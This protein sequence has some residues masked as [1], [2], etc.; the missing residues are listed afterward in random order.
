M[1]NKILYWTLPVWLYEMYRLRHKKK[2]VAYFNLC[3][4]KDLPGDDYKSR[5]FDLYEHH[6]NLQSDYGKILAELNHLKCVKE[7]PEWY[8]SQKELKS[9]SSGTSPAKPLIAP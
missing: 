1:I 5:Y 7:H 6:N 8:K 4:Y 3:G 9:K 2:K